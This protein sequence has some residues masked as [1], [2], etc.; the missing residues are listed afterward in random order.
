MSDTAAGIAALAKGDIV[1]LLIPYRGTPPGETAYVSFPT[2]RNS[3]SDIEADNQARIVVRYND[4]HAY[5]ESSSVFVGLPLT[6]NVQDFF[7]KDR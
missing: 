7:R 5:I 6:V 4:S 3:W 1:D 2:Y